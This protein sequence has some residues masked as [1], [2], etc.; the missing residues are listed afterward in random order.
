MKF[1]ACE[2]KKLIGRRQAVEFKNLLQ[3]IAG[4]WGFTT[5]DQSYPH[6]GSMQ[7]S[8][9][10]FCTKAASSFITVYDAINLSQSQK[11]VHRPLDSLANARYT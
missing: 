1:C 11:I 5:L 10:G 7:R 3:E 8:C 4:I 2:T 6:Q 9:F